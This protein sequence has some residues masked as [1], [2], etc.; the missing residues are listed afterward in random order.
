VGELLLTHLFEGVEIQYNYAQQTL[1]N[2]A[3]L[4][5][6][7]VNLVTVIDEKP[8]ILHHD[9]KELKVVDVLTDSKAKKEEETAS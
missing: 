2:L 9:G 8:K 7:P 3:S 1:R 4:W 5:R 6:R